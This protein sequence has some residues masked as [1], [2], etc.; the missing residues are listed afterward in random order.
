ML[1]INLVTERSKISY[2][3][4]VYLIYLKNRIFFN[5][6]F[7]F[8]HLCSEDRISFMKTVDI[9]EIHSSTALKW[10]MI[11]GELSENNLAFSLAGKG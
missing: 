6:M 1:L 10:Y 8:K 4:G 3:A 9:L 5:V 11:H 7:C 2:S